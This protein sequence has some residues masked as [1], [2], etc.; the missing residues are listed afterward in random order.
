MKIV[1]V[2]IIANVRLNINVV[3]IAIAVKKLVIVMTLVMALRSINAV[4]T[5]VVISSI[6]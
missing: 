4:R 6:R 1:L 3:M 5:N 2:A